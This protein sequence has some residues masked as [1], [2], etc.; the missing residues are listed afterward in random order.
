MR[1]SVKR[2]LVFTSSFP[3]R[4]N[5]VSGPFI[6]ALAREEAK[7][8]QITV[9]AP[10][11]G[12]SPSFEER[13][14]MKIFY[15]WQGVGRIELAG[16]PGGILPAL[17]RNRFLLFMLPF[18]LLSAFFSLVRIVR[19]E[20]ID[21]IHVH[22]VL[23]LG[24]IAAFYCFLTGHK[25]KLLMTCHGSDLLKISG[26]FA[27]WIKR[28]SLAQAN[29]VTV[30]SEHLRHKVDE[31]GGKKCFVLPMGVDTSLFSPEAGRADFRNRF[32]LNRN[33]ILFV[34]SLIELKG[35]RALVEAMPEVIRKEPDTSL[36]LVGGGELEGALRHF[37]CD[38]G[39]EKHVVF[40]GPQLHSDLP[41]FFAGSDIFILPSFS[42]GWPLVVMEALSAG[43][44][45][46]VSKL[47]VFMDHPD[48]EAL[49]IPVTAGDA[50]EI[51]RVLIK[52]LRDL[53]NKDSAGHMRRRSYALQEL[54]ISVIGRRYSDLIKSLL[55]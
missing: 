28:F 3:S 29:A 35:V 33:V 41:A 39:L 4:A 53:K 2:V 49:F 22:W 36:L 55:Q 20:K 43:I 23:P 26:K 16:Q 27:G 31:L 5:P 51:A 52:T 34:G 42:E 44:P 8:F 15:F 54:D 14:Q 17:K 13:D 50:G 1:E 6:E 11:C 25:V 9:L 40:A 32:N 46:I 48:R 19:Q 37:V 47:P 18:F 7:K 24:W 38:T 30:V 12:R 45:V 21:L 10:R